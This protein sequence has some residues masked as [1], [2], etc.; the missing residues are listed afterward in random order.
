MR[1]RLAEGDKGQ[2]TSLGRKGLETR[3]RLLRATR[4]LLQTLSPLHLTVA[5]IAKAA[6]TV[7]GT[8]YCKI[9][10]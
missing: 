5:A 7:Q 6:N 2:P 3:A 4:D 8:F 9:N 1:A 10:G